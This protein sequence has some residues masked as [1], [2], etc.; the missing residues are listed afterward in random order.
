MALLLVEV[1]VKSALAQIIK[2]LQKFPAKTVL[3]KVDFILFDYRS[4]H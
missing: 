3:A 1:V 2:A 4:E